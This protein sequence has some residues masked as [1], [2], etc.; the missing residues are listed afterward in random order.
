MG[1]PQGS[2]FVVAISGIINMTSSS[3][4]TSLYADGVATF[5]CFGALT[6]LNASYRFSI[7]YVSHW[8][9]ENGFSFSK[10]DPVCTFHTL[11]GF[12]STPHTLSE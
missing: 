11:E 9:L 6:P 1:V 8:V 7:N 2:M 5:Y 3:V 12:S 4:M 10:G